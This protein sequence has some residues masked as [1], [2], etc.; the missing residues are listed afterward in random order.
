MNQ[1]VRK[2]Q[3]GSATEGESAAL[4]HELDDA[5]SR[6]QGCFSELLG[7]FSLPSVDRSELT[8]CRLRIARL[9]LSRSLLINKIT[10]HL[11]KAASAEE[12]VLLNQIAE[13]HQRLLRVA[14]THTTR[15][16]LEAIEADW[17]GYRAVTRKLI[18]NWQEK[19]GWEEEVLKPLL[20]RQVPTGWG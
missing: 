5:H 20:R 17:D 3:I 19:M 14:S 1:P 18:R 16:S 11:A 7:I 10:A 13:G 9:R 15:W 2:S 12:S 8:S 6:L 4:L